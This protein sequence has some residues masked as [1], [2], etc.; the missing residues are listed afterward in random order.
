MSAFLRRM[1]PAETLVK[2]GAFRRRNARSNQK[3]TSKVTCE[4][5]ALHR[6]SCALPRGR[7]T[8]GAIHILKREAQRH[9]GRDTNGKWYHWET[10]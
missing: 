6:E 10:W 9:A 5:D 2:C 7:E 4:K 8:D 3:S 1:E